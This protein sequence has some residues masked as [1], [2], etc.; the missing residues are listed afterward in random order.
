MNWLV[1]TNF[2]QVWLLCAICSQTCHTNCQV[3]IDHSVWLN[4]SILS[5]NV[6]LILI[7]LF[8]LMVTTPINVELDYRKLQTISPLKPV[9]PHFWLVNEFEFI[10]GHEPSDPSSLCWRIAHLR[11]LFR[12]TAIPIEVK[13]SWY[14]KH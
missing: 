3:K 10:S 7:I 13:H 6:S 12:M 9:W 5:Q 2:D 11:R 14:T 1:L 4:M 8:H